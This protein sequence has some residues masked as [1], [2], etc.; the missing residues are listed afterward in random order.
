[1]KMISMLAMV[2]C[3]VGQLVGDLTVKDVSGQ[4]CDK[5]V[6][7]TAGY[8]RLT[9]G[10]D[11]HYFYWSFESRNKP[12]TDP[13]VLWM[14][15]G[16]GCSSEVALFGENGPCKVNA[17]G[18]DTI[19]NPYSWNSNATVIY[20]D[21]P[22]GTGFSYGTGFDHNED[23]IATDMYNFLQHFFKS[24]GKL[25]HLPF[26]VFGESYAGH[27]VP[28]TTHRI[29]KNNK[30]LKPGHLHINLKG[31]SVGNGLT[32]PEIQYR[33]YPEMASST[34]GHNAAIGPVEVDAMKAAVIPC[35][36]EIDACN[37][38]V[39]G[40]CL[41]AVDICN[42]G[43]LIPYT[44]TGMNPYDMRVKCAKPPL[45]YDFSNVKTYLSNPT[46]QKILGVEG[47]KWEDC[48]HLVNIF[49]T[50]DWMKNYQQDLPEQLADGIRVQ[51]Y[52]GDQ[53]YICNWLGNKAWTKAMDWPGKAAFNAAPDIEWSI[54]G[55]KN[56]S[57]KVR[58]AQ[59]F[60][61][62]QVYNAGHMVPMN[63]PAAALYMLNEFIFPKNNSL[64]A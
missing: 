27:Y 39:S 7:Q 40:S 49:M 52:A 30:N 53:D 4:I 9:T 1:M 47:R 44:A 46:V 10:L 3:A 29:W 50:G 28:A 23:G 5:N 32:D 6:N 42:I 8:Y 64:F 12:E 18:T 48:N 63:Q 54:P 61:F 21:Q 51:L 45:C 13:V 33:Y 22:T 14:T 15:G 16:P 20:I 36:A 37:K 26:Y 11:K 35:I 17:D 59:G 57:G 58:S 24:H 34:N 19:N 60:A 56:T 25:Q 38:N 2:G 62:V 43:L 41:E 31:V 55:H